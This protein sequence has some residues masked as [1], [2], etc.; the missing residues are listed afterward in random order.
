MN[1][2]T[3]YYTYSCRLRLPLSTLLSVQ[4][5]MGVAWSLLQRKSSVASDFVLAMEKRRDVQLVQHPVLSSVP[6]CLFPATC[7]QITGIP[8]HATSGILKTE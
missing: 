8:C 6:T 5:V 1:T 3:K 4:E 2:H 7:S